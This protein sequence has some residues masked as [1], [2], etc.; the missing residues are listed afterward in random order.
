M[1]LIRHEEEPEMPEK[2]PK[3]PDAAIAKIAAWIDHGAPYDAPL[4]AGKAPPRAKSRV[5]DEDRKWWSFQPLAKVTPPTGA[6]HPVD[7]FLL[8]A[9]KAKG[10]ALNPPTDAP[11]LIRRASLDLTGLPPRPISQAFT[12]GCADHATLNVQLSTFIDGLSLARLRRAVGAAWLDVARFAESSGFEHDTIAQIPSRTATCHQALNADMPFEQFARWQVAGDEF[13]PGDP[14]ALMATGF[15]GAGV[16]PTQITANEV[17]RTRYDALDDMLSTTGSAFLGLSV[18]CARCHDHKFDPIPTND[19]YRLL[20]TFTTT[21]RSNIDIEIEPEKTKALRAVWSKEGEA[22]AAAVVKVESALRP[23][24][25]QWLA[26]GVSDVGASAWMLLEPT[27]LKSNS[28][29]TFKPLGD[30]SYLVE[31]TNGAH[32]AYT[33]TAPVAEKHIT[34]LRLE[35]LTHPSMKSRDQAAR[36][37]AA[38]R[39]RD[40]RDDD[41]ERRQARGGEDRAHSQITNRTP[42]TSASRRRR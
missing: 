21:V 29:A 11:T 5:T 22:L 15:L 33:I 34:A 28:K 37:T 41:A 42:P 10:L 27:E 16:F 30:G 4:I 2:K 13:A 31:G 36:T 17:E 20:S 23:A 40:R 7:A 25:D 18:G 6:A 14:L 35:A 1:K 8:E 26:S 39:S 38:S 9:G 19:Y 3:L 12:R 32:D 24:F